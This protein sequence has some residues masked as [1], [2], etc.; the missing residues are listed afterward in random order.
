MKSLMQKTVVGSKIKP[1]K[2]KSLLIIVPTFLVFFFGY[3]NCAP[4]AGTPASAAGGS[5][6]IGYFAKWVS[7]AD[8]GNSAI[9]ENAGN[10][11]IGTTDPEFNLHVYGSENNDNGIEVVTQNTSPGNRAYTGYALLNDVGYAWLWLGSTAYYT[12]SEPGLYENRLI[13]ESGPTVNGI[14]LTTKKTTGD[15]RMFTG[16]QAAAQER[17]RIASDGNVGIGTTDTSTY[18]LNVLGNVNAS[19]GYTQLSDIHLKKNFEPLENSLQKILQLKG[20]SFYWKDS[21]FDSSKQIGF[22]AQ[23][24]EKIFPEIIKTDSKGYKAMS[25][26]QLAAPIVEAIREVNSENQKLKQ[27]NLSLKARLQKIEQ[28]L[29]IIQAG[30]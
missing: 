5:G 27:E 6:T 19:G 29:G 20:V 24:V 1:D 25:Y 12:D 15:I 4:S 26:S 17:L 11:G 30:Q 8:L 7:T 18:K 21:S 3:T 16:G 13:L 2:I 14:N 9:F 28:V 23:Q 22:V 10:I